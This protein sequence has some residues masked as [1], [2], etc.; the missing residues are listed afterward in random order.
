MVKPVYDV[1]VVA[2]TVT[3]DDWI[4]LLL[5]LDAL[6]CAARITLC[7]PYM[8][9]SRQD[10]QNENESFGVSMCCRLLE[11]M[12]ISEC[13]L[14][15]NHS[16]PLFRI[17]TYHLSARC[18]FEASIVSKYV[19]KQITIV[20]P[21]IGGAYRANEYAL[22]IGC[23]LAICNKT[24]NVFGQLKKSDVLGNVRDKI[25]IL[26]DDIVDSGATLCHAAEALEQQGCK[27]VVA[28]CSHGVLSAGAIDRLGKSIITEIVL[29]DSI[30]NAET[31]SAKIRKLSIASLM[32]ETIR[33]IV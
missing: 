3:N 16:E 8:G 21:D 15:D 24:K 14:L 22:S 32:A 10:K 13:I 30:A 18:V 2:S 23:D 17:P 31:V 9:Y 28:Y 20:S 11:S 1:V 29:T 7:M 27:G 4:E 19:P 12:G 25:C 26:I 33:S 6:R 5:L